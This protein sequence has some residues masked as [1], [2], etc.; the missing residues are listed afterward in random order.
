MSTERKQYRTPIKKLVKFFEQSR[1][2][3]K[4]KCLEAK[5]RINWTFA[6]S[7]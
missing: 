3:W 1:D 7:G 4:A 2:K 6:I 5:Q